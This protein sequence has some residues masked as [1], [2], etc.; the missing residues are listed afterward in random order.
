MKTCEFLSSC[1]FYNDLRKRRPITLES[2]KEEYCDSN[3]TQCARF[4]VSRLHGPGRVSKY[5]FP[6]D[7][8]EACKILDERD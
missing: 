7:I 8:Q 5:L 6:E 3:Y 4:M 1:D 2:V